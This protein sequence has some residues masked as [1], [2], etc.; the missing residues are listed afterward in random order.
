[1]DPLIVL[2]LFLAVLLAAAVV[3]FLR[4]ATRALRTTRQIARFQH[5]AAQLGARLDAVLDQLGQRVD[6][7][8]RR[9][10]PADELQPQI[11]EALRVLEAGAE[12]A[13]S[14]SAPVFLEESR[15][16]LIEEI[17]RA[18]RATEM[19]LHGCELVTGPQSRERDPEAQTAVKRGYLNLLHA[20]EALAEHVANLAEARDPAASKWRTSRT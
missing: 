17:E 11:E 15:L 13:R 14:I 9:E 4:R 12:E 7:L 2:P 5:D 18:M 6:R 1:M 20:R 16:G 3:V 8:R 10:V 19:V